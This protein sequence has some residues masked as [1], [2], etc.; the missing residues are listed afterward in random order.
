ML[1]PAVAPAAAA[2][3]GRLQAVPSVTVAP[4]VTLK[5]LTGRA[6]ADPTARSE[7]TSVAWFH[8]APGRASAWSH[9]RSG[10]ESFFIL[11]G[12]G[13]VRTGTGQQPVGPGDFILIPPAVVR[14][15]AAASNESLT[16]YAVTSPAWS[17]QDD[18]LDA[19]PAP[20]RRASGP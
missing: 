16:F 17:R 9:N 15:I 14:S 4:G 19:A 7:R 13:A 3:V 18:V 20:E 5:E 2:D 6:V 11:S 10:E 8:L 12:H 1:I